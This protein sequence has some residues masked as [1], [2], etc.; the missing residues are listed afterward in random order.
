M[1]SFNIYTHPYAFVIEFRYPLKTVGYIFD[2]AHGPQSHINLKKNTAFLQPV[3]VSVDSKT[4][5]SDMA[6]PDKAWKD[7]AAMI[8]PGTAPWDVSI[9]EAD[10]AKLKAGVDSESMD[11]RWNIWS[12]EES[13]NNNILVH[14]ARSWTG[15]KLYILHVKPN[16]GDSGNGA[17]IEA[18]TWAQ[19]KGG[20]PISEEQGKKDAVV[21]TRAQLDCKIEALPEYDFNDTWDNPAARRVVEEQQRQK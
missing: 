12:T 6:F 1:S 17:K 8:E 16:D 3:L 21:I 10:F 18:I 11:D 15:N 9:S 14:Y 19:D 4:R 2:N 7:R 5:P 20:V 13:Q